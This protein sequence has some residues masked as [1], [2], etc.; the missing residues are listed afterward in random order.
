MSRHYQ[1]QDYYFE[2][3]KQKGYNA[4]SVFKLQEIQEKYRII[5]PNH[6]ILDIGCF[7]GSFLQILST[8]VGKN[9]KVVGFDIKKTKDLGLENVITFV[10]DVNDLEN[11]REQLDNL[12]NK[13][14]NNKTRKQEVVNQSNLSNKSNISNQFNVII[15]DIA[16][17]TSGHPEYDQYQ[18][19]L[20]N[21]KV[22]E[23][24]KTNLKDG[25]NMILKIFQGSDF[26]EFLAKLKK[27]FK[28]V[29]IFKPKASRARSSEMYLLCY[30][31][32]K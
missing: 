24:A 4:R 9:G 28:K 13:Q 18:S 14:K 22:I 11:V 32:K 10:A 26:N 17:N 5:K 29:K 30:E 1:F 16:P 12:A 2:L 3:A 20:L 27:S 15:S 31:F 7:P 19:I 21:E 23:L 25:G 8:W 6:Y